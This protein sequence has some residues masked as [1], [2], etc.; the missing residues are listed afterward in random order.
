MDV[1]LIP[2]IM[3]LMDCDPKEDSTSQM[4]FA[5]DGVSHQ[6]S[7]A[8]NT[9]EANTPTE[10]TEALAE[11]NPKA[12]DEH[13]QR[14]INAQLRI[15]E[16]QSLIEEKNSE[17]QQLK[18]EFMRNGSWGSTRTHTLWV[19]D[20]SNTG[21][22]EAKIQQL[23]S[24][25]SQQ[26][27]VTDQWIENSRIQQEN[28]D[29]AAQ[30]SAAAWILY[31]E[32]LNRACGAEDELATKN[33][34]GSAYEDRINTLETIIDNLK[35]QNKELQSK[36]ETEKTMKVKPRRVADSSKVTDDEI[37]R[38]W[39][40]MRY[41]IGIMAS[42][43][44]TDCPSETALHHDKSNTFC[45]L[46]RMIRRDIWNLEDED[47]RP[48]MVERYIWL[49]VIETVFKQNGNG[50]FGKSWAGTVGQS[51][52]LIID[53]LANT[54]E[55]SAMDLS[56]LI[57]WKSEGGKMIND[58]LGVDKG[59]LRRLIGAMTNLFSHFLPR[60]RNGGFKGFDKLEKGLQKVLQDAVQLQTIFMS[61]KAQFDVEWLDRPS[62]S[63][64][65]YYRPDSMEAEG[66]E[67]EP[68]DRGS[69][70][71]FHLSPSLMKQGTA[72]GDSYDQS[73]QL[74][75]ARVICD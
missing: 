34:A 20:Q 51:F 71:L 21:Q 42:N 73:I 69:M 13:E 24:E 14:Q 49:A 15:E 35:T 41:N 26:K 54:I 47:N 5:G 48:F 43:V 57:H 66:H 50:K 59:E 46:V 22:L 38:I 72:D 23:T 7:Q 6:T 61:S 30:D 31:Y 19:Q 28:V 12:S 4:T 44:L 36:L 8:N 17:I 1:S 56:K 52:S 25:L 40:K 75:K 65:V 39:D 33:S 68:L 64:N 53:E 18:Q 58:L 9:I 32:A 45:D 74:T 10:S 11:N 55:D 70:I 29:K 62:R 27:A 2:D 37:V 3:D 60:D 63:Q 16:L 67:K